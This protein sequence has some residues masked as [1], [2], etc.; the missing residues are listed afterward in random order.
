MFVSF[1]FRKNLT[2]CTRFALLSLAPVLVSAQTDSQP[3]GQPAVHSPEKLFDASSLRRELE[4][5]QAQVAAHPETDEARA[6][7]L[8]EMASLQSRVGLLREAKQSSQ[9][10]L[11]MPVQLPAEYRGVNHFVLANALNLL[12]G[13]PEM[14]YLEAAHQFSIAGPRA[15]IR[16]ALTYAELAMLYLRRQNVRGSEESLQKSLHAISGREIPS[17]LHVIQI[18]TGAHIALAQGRMTD[19]FT[20]LGEV[21]RTSGNDPLISPDLRSH[22]SRDLAEL[23]VEGGQL[24]EA[25]TYL[26]NSVHLQEANGDL[27]QA[28]VSLAMLG[29]IHILLKAPTEASAAF[30]RAETLLNADPA[31]KP[32]EVS[33]VHGYHG[34]FLVSQKD[35]QAGRECLRK[36]L[37]AGASDAQFSPIRRQCLTSLLTADRRLGNKTEAKEIRAELKHGGTVQEKSQDTVD[38]MTLKRGMRS[39]H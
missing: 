4:G 32:F 20:Q 8:T 17:S 34:I 22:I 28:A 11:S 9:T 39:E 23:C 10:V 24:D 6:T 16:L 19:A 3:G 25:V 21:V 26:H 33:I 27:G 36:A 30:Q 29:S 35:W 1:L 38:L 14:E 31:E 2:F 5:L 7:L 12:G 13:E 37:R 15:R 18:D